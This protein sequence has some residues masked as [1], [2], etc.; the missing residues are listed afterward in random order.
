MFHAGK[1]VKT[2]KYETPV[3]VALIPAIVAI[4]GGLNKEI[5]ICLETPYIELEAVQAYMDWE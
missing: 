4:Q 3:L 5:H 2:M 1:E